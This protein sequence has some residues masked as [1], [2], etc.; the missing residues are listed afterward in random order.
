MKIFATGVS[1]FIGSHLVDRLVAD[2]HQV[3]CLVRL[4]SDT[5]RLN[6][7]GV[8]YFFEMPDLKDYDAVF[9]I[10]GVLGHPGI[11]LEVYRK[12]HV[13]LTERLLAGMNRH[14]RFVYMSSNYVNCAKKPYEETKIEGENVV[15]ASGIDYA[16]VRPGFVFGPRDYHHLPLFKLIK[17]L[18]VFPLVGSGKNIVAPTYVEDVVEALVYSIDSKERIVPVAGESITM[19]KFIG[20]IAQA[21]GREIKIMYMPEKLLRFQPF[22]NWFKVDFFTQNTIFASYKRGRD[23]SE[24]LEETV[25]WYNNNRLLKG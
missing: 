19:E 17:A 22:R 4:A 3:E 15:R 7:L 23:L 12:A 11:P 1:G 24:G 16:I 8:V 20:A 13:G 9:H 18:P 6:R 10:A 2:G 5:H 14:Q 21:I 25:A